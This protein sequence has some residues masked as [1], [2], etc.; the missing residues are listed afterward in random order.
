VNAGW[1]MSSALHGWLGLYEIVSRHDW[2]EQ[3]NK[4]RHEDYEQFHLPPPTLRQYQTLLYSS[5]HLFSQL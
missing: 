3:K 5:I 2:R 4:T 1:R